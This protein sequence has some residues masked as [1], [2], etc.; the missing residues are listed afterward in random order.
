M[1]PTANLEE[2]RKL[3]T[4][5][6]AGVAADA[7]RLA[8]LFQALD[9]WISNG[10]VLPDAWKVPRNENLR[11]PADYSGGDYEFD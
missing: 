2:Q 6:L 7:E 1:D 9:L 4:A 3:T 5:I 11:G 8:E 10:G